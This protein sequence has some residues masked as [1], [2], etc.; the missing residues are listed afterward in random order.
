MKTIQGKIL[1]V[2]ILGFLIL[3]LSLCL[4]SFFVLRD[5]MHKNAETLI[6]TSAREEAAYIN[7]LLGCIEDSVYILEEYAESELESISKLSE[8]DYRYDYTHRIGD[9]FYN[10]ARNTDGIESFYVRYSPVLTHSQAGFFV[11]KLANGEFKDLPPTDI[12]NYSKDDTEYVGWY[13]KPIEAGQAIWLKPYENKNIGVKM[14]S[15]ITPLE[16]T[17]ENGEKEVFGVCGIDIN[18][19]YFTSLI[20]DFKVYDTGYSFIRGDDG[21][22]FYY[23]ERANEIHI[24]NADRIEESAPLSNGMN[25]VIRVNHTEVEIN[26]Q[27]FFLTVFVVSF[28]ILL[29]FIVITTILVRRM[30]KPLK[31]LTKAAEEL[32]NGNT[33]VHCDCTTNDEVG[34][35]AAVFNDTASKLKD[36]MSYINSLAYRD[37]LTGVKNRTAFIEAATAINNKIK[38]HSADFGILMADING[39]KRA[40]DI[41]GHD[42]GNRL[43]VESIKVICN[44]FK[45]SPVFRIGGD[46]FA[47]ILEGSDLQNH[48][49][50]IHEMS[51]IY[52][53]TYVEVDAERLPIMMAHGVAIYNSSLDRDFDDVMNRADQQMYTNK[54]DFKR[55]N[56]EET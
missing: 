9:F 51:S 29:I 35:L 23:P 53:K 1:T 49:A 11:Q 41:Y 30:T 47:V 46:E 50:L 55:R 31:Q 16:W 48:R 54:R 19:D 7:G 13:Y 15:F 3:S 37:S 33:N 24:A 4:L 32:A 18:F 10:V 17:N 34:R 5:V 14:I 22:V 45:H 39:L 2:V 21:E 28:S 36:Y 56:G 43:I 25:F 38:T 6:S 44:V 40:N 42:V 27:G 52:F 12:T 26:R 8:Y 20:D